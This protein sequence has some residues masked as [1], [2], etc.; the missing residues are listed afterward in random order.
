[1]RTGTRKKS[2]GN[3]TVNYV[4]FSKF[5]FKESLLQI[6]ISNI[7]VENV[8]IGYLKFK[9]SLEIRNVSAG[10]PAN[11]LL[12]K[13]AAIPVSSISLSGSC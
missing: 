1:M 6:R 8:K 5:A 12:C 3:F 2:H 7:T 11:V 13:L 10:F 9:K 4:L